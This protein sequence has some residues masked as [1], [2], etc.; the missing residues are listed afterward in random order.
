MALRRERPE[1]ETERV[2][3]RFP[4]EL[5]RELRR[6]VPPRKRSQV[7]IAGTAKMLAEIKLKEALKAGAGAWSDESHP[8]L[9]TQEDINRYLENL[10]RSTDERIGREG[11]SA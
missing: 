2:N 8:D 11:L 9:K 3:V 7:I 10:R 4:R 5:M 1:G 6:Y